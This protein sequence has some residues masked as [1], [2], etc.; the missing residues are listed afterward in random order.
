MLAAPVNFQPAPVKSLI[1]NAVLPPALARASVMMDTSRSRTSRAVSIQLAAY[2]C[3][4]LLTVNCRY[5][6]TSRDIY[7]FCWRSEIST[8][9][10]GIS[11]ISTFL[12]EIRSIYVFLWDI[13]YSHVFV[14]DQLYPRFCGRSEISTFSWEIRNIHVF[15]GDQKYPR[16]CGKQKY[17]R[18]CGR[19]EIATFLWET[20]ISTFLWEIRAFS[21]CLCMAIFLR[22]GRSC[23]LF[24]MQL[25]YSPLPLCLCL[26]VSVSLCLCLSPLPRPLSFFLA[27]C[28]HALPVFC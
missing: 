24:Y 13:S 10:C 1:Q 19:S 3:I 5:N 20:E 27:L 9:F 22:N 23:Y 8:F 26:S 4:A 21:H 28:P 14:G 17:P 11:A 16:F 2:R 7:V 25:P 6:Y 15:V 12:W 18:F